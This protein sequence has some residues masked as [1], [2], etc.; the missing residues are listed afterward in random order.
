MVRLGADKGASIKASALER[1]DEVCDFPHKFEILKAH[2]NSFMLFSSCPGQLLVQVQPQATE[3]D[4]EPEE[5]PKAISKTEKPNK[6]A[7]RKLEDHSR[8]VI[9]VVEQLKE[10]VVVCPYFF[11]L[12]LGH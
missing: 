2:A 1:L 7:N 12:L 6:P 10:E 4:D 8:P 11:F 3:E 9:N 5:R